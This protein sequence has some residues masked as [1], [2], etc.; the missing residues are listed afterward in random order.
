LHLCVSVG[1]STVVQCREL[2]QCT[3]FAEVRLDLI[4][5]LSPVDVK[6]LFCKGRRTIATCR[7]G[8]FTEAERLALLAAAIEAGAAFVDLDL[9]SDL[10][11]GATLFVRSLLPFA[12]RHQCRLIASRHFFDGLPSDRILFTTVRRLSTFEPAFIKVA[13][14]VE[15]ETEVLRLLAL[16]LLDERV[17]PVGMGPWGAVSRA[18]ALVLGAPFTYVSPEK[19]RSTAPGQ[20]DSTLVRMLRHQMEKTLTSSFAS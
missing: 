2:L 13:S 9:D 6:H 19:G 14:R 20:P 8:R 10:K 15:T 3:A 12:Q 4:D 17:V 16:M 7:T 18:A 5:D 1:E 11:R